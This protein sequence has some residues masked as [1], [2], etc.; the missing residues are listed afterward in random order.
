MQTYVTDSAEAVR[1][2]VKAFDAELTACYKNDDGSIMHSEINI[3][4]SI[5]AV[6]E[7]A[8]EFAILGDTQT[9]N[10]MQFCL[11]FGEGGEEAVTKAYDTLKTGAKILMPLAPCTYSPLM[12]DIIDCY[13]VRWCLFV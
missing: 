12:C 13:G 3:N 6:S 1:L 7:R 4:G 2:Y 5:L 11:Q 10:V 8:S 9:G